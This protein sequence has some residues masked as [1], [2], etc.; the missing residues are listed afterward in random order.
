MNGESRG[1]NSAWYEWGCR[2]TAWILMVVC[3]GTM[4]IS[5][6]ALAGTTHTITAPDNGHEYEVYQIF[7]GDETEGILSNVKWGENGSGECGAGVPDSILKEIEGAQGTDA[8]KL[9]IIKKYARLKREEAFETISEGQ[10]LSVPSGYYLIKDKD[11]S[12]AGKNDAYTTW[13]VKIVGD[14][15]MTP[16]ADKPSSEKKVKDRND[17]LGNESDWQD[18]ADY[19][20]D[21]LVPFRLMGKVASNYDSYPVYRFVFHDQQSDGLE[22]QADTVHVFVDGEEIKQGF[23]VKESTEDGD[24]FEVIFENMKTIP[25]VKADSV[26]TV[27][28]ESRLNDQAAL[29]AEG[30]PN[31]MYLEYSNNPNDG[32]GGET[33]KTPEDTVIVFTYKV[34]VK[35]QDET[36]KALEGAEFVLEKQLSD[37]D[38]GEEKWQSFV[39]EKNTTGTV[40]T[41]RGLDD[42]A[43]RLTESVTPAGYNT[44]PALYF[45]ITAEHQILSDSPVL[46]ALN[47]EA[48]TGEITF[49]SDK[50]EGFL[51]TTVIN[52]HGVT[53]PETGGRGTFLFYAVGGALMMV[54]TGAAWMYLMRRPRGERKDEDKE[55]MD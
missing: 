30:N 38:E 12:Q 18:S 26:V 53:L 44:V 9:A 33:G 14:V 49:V 6:R 43:Y 45:T 29:G 39:P 11:G 3:M 2:F 47:G 52:K 19:D 10:V 54:S 17:T 36:G 28:Y 5:I 27:E 34:V 50:E 40:F 37:T 13:L 41:F 35:K 4:V 25:E 20:V 31:K 51:E 48:A 22:F 16:K 7:V 1:K 42:G 15:K 55:E 46:E 24:A 8:E 32:Q 21:D 23:S